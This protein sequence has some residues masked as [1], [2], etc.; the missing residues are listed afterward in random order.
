MASG[1]N[2]WIAQQLRQMAQL[3][4]AQGDNPYRVA[5]YRRAGDL[6]AHLP[7]SVREIFEREGETGLDALPGI[8][9]HIAAAIDEMLRSGR[10]RRLEQLRGDADPLV[11]L[12][13]VPGVGSALAQQLHES[14]GISSLEA[15][16][17]AAQDGRLEHLPQVGARRA[18]AIGAALTQ[19]LDHGRAWRNAPPRPPSPQEPPVAWLLDVDREYRAAAAAGTLPTIA[20]RRFNPQGEAW[21]PVLHTQ[22]GDWHFTALFSNTARAHALGRVRDWVVIYA[23]DKSL[24]ER[25]HTVVTVQNGTL[26]GRRVV[27][28]MEAAC[29]AWYRR[30]VAGA[31]P[32]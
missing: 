11:L 32:A 13:T 23:E 6:L 5:A 17:L 4:A 8:G 16:E 26:A 3:L 12:R 31:A 20:P 29:Q 28:G 2:A 27:R 19:M 22:R 24:G 15:L 9:P 7:R 10:W 14:L 1:D 21:L 25:Q 30:A 18:M